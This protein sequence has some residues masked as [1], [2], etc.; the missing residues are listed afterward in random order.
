MTNKD[1]G[2]EEEKVEEAHETFDFVE[3]F[4]IIGTVM[5][6]KWIRLYL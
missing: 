1:V 3:F 4:Q 6:L 5:K 2:V